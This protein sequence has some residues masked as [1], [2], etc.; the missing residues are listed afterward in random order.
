MARAVGQTANV[1][2]A[3]ALADAAGALEPDLRL[4]CGQSLG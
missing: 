3:A 4:V 2:P 1:R